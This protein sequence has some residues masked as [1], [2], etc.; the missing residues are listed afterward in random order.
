L[1]SAAS[2]IFIR[3]TFRSTRKIKKINAGPEQNAPAMK[4]GV[5]EGAGFE[6]RE[7][8][9]RY[10]VDSDRKR[11]RKKD[12]R[13]YDLRIVFPTRVRLEQN[14]GDDEPVDQEI[15]VQ[16]EDVPGQQ[17]MRKI[18]RSDDWHQM[19]D[20][21]GSPEI[22]RDEEHAHDD[23][24]DRE[25]FTDDHDFA[26]RAPI[27]DVCGNDQY[28]G[29]GRHSDQECEVSDIETPGN[30]VAHV[31]SDQSVFDLMNVGSHTHRDQDSEHQQP[32]VVVP[33]TADD[34]EKA[35]PREICEELQVCASAH[36]SSSSGC[37][38]LASPVSRLR[39]SVPQK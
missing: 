22:D 36:R 14:V 24:C 25:Q 10:R 16:N 1:K 32:D 29:S 6:A 37:S 18:R 7:E 19:P 2:E 3:P 9:R 21:L 30:L 12:D 38:G 20:E 26:N 23:G 27:V 4:R 35:S 34:R 8:E 28:D 5:P 17:R 33:A 15:E 11:N 39:P 31:R 13:Q